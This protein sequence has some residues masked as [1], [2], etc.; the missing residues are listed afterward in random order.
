MVK[1]QV[2]IKGEIVVTTTDGAVAFSVTPGKG[3]SPISWLRKAAC[4]DSTVV[5]DAATVLKV[6][7]L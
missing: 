2:A 1:G 4:R 6:R 3:T 7:S 5:M